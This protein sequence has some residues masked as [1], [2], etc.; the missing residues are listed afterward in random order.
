MASHHEPD[1]QAPDAVPNAVPCRYC[2]TDLRDPLGS[3]G[4]KGRYPSGKECRL[5]RQTKEAPLKRTMSQCMTRRY[6][7]TLGVFNWLLTQGAVHIRVLKCASEKGLSFE[8][9]GLLCDLVTP[10]SASR[11]AVGLA[12]IGPP[13]SACSVSWPGGTSCLTKASSKRALKR[14]VFSASATHQP[15]TRRLKMSRMTYR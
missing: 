14:T 4:G 3:P 8:V 13:R 12:F 5:D 11:K 9:C 2:V 1:V 10:R 7:V 15:T 6:C